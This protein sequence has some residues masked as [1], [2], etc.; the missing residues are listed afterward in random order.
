MIISQVSYRTNG[1]LVLE[2]FQKSEIL[3]NAVSGRW[4]VDSRCLFSS[5][6][7][8]EPDEGVLCCLV[9]TVVSC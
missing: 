8:L 5:K 1:P 9:S 7:K 2:V 3:K 4:C 6:S